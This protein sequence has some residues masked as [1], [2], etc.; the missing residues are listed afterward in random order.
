MASSPVDSYVAKLPTELRSVAEALRRLILT[1]LDVEERLA[2]GV[3]FYYGKGRVCDLNY[4][5]ADNVIDLGFCRGHEMQ[6]L[7]LLEVKD[8]REVRTIEFAGLAE[9]DE[10]SIKELL[11]EADRLDKLRSWKQAVV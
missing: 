8:R 3:P 4:R 1:T 10:E 2:Y 6:D 5:A 7:G 9:I 11:L